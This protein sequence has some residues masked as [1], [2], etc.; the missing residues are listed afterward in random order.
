MRIRLRKPCFL[1]RRRTLGW[2]VRFM[3][4]SRRERVGRADRLR[5]AYPLVKG[6]RGSRKPGMARERLPTD[7]LAKPALIWHI[8][9]GQ[10]PL[11]RNAFPRCDRD[12]YSAYR[13]ICRSCRP[14]EP[15][16]ILAPCRT[17]RWYFPPVGS[18][19]ARRVDGGKGTQRCGFSTA[20]DRSVEKCGE[21]LGGH[22][23]R[24]IPPLSGISFA[25]RCAGG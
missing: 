23:W 4:V 14:L 21:A 8:L 19:A 20:V 22:R 2:K 24:R 7:L 17:A 5:R 12:R 16:H 10:K 11:C 9:S 18:L 6:E 13:A 25:A 15:P 3:G 1:L